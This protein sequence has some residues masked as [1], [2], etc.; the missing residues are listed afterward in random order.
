MVVYFRGMIVNG[1]VEDGSRPIKA[2][3]TKPNIM[4]IDMLSMRSSFRVEVD[5]CCAYP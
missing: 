4:Y 5:L 2:H 3:Q 1:P